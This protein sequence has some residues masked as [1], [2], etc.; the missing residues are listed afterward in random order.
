MKLEK[1]KLNKIILL[2]L[3]LIGSKGNYYVLS[4]A[5]LIVF[6]LVVLYFFTIS[7]DFSK[8]KNYY[9]IFT[10]LYILI[11]V[12]Y[13]F[14]FGYIELFSTLKSFLKISIGFIVAILIKDKLFDNY[15]SIISKLSLITI[16]FYIFQCIDIKSLDSIL[17]ILEST[18]PGLNL[19]GES[20]TNIFIFT[21]NQKGS[22]DSIYRNSGFAWEPK[23]FANML[24]IAIIINLFKYK[25]SLNRNFYILIFCLLTTFSTTAYVVGFLSIILLFLINL[26]NKAYSVFFLLFAISIGYFIITLPF[27]YAKIVNEINSKEKI[28]AYENDQSEFKRRSMGRFGS[29]KMDWNDFKD[30]PLLGVGM[31]EYERTQNK[32]T[33]LVRVNGLSDLISRFGIIGIILF[34]VGYYNFSNGLT[35]FYNYKGAY[36]IIVTML[37][38]NFSSNLILNPLWLS[39]QFISIKLIKKNE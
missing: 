38:L 34:I 9:T 37:L 32:N 31:Q 19:K 28:E 7:K 14:E 12:F 4:D 26:K 29:L 36:V 23:G 10:L 8:Y 35:N 13:T 2:I 20:V 22:L 15:E 6:Y 27:V 21:L 24:I 3:I 16:P 25:F 11:N 39:F 30:K 17:K 33:F 5:M 1:E 18:M